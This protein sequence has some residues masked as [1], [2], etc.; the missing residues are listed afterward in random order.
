MYS[1]FFFGLENSFVCPL[2]SILTVQDNF[3]LL[4]DEIITL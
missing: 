4:P 1:V 3:L 2:R